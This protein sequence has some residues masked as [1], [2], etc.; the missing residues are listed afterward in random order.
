MIEI[1]EKEPYRDKKTGDCV[2]PTYMRKD[3]EDFFMFNRSSSEFDPSL[4]EAKMQL[5]NSGGKCFRFFANYEDPM[6]M[7]E[8]V[9]KEHRHFSKTS[10]ITSRDAKESNRFWNFAGKVE[11]VFGSN[12]LYSIYDLE[13]I[14]KIKTV[15]EHIDR[16]EWH[17]ALTVINKGK[18]KER[19]EHNDRD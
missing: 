1:I 8:A 11:G 13:L 12:F 15:Q 18:A 3:N 16:E 14:V 17:K 19:T 9:V 10:R 4:D 5:I 7:L 6:G 2:F